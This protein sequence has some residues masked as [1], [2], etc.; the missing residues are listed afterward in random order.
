MESLTK[1]SRAYQQNSA[2]LVRWLDRLS[3]FDVSIKYKAGENLELTDSLNRNP[4]KEA[5][6]EENYEEDYVISFLSDFFKLNH[7]NGQRLNMDREIL[8]TSQTMNV[9]LATRRK[10]THEIA[11]PR[12]NISEVKP[13]IFARK[14]T[15]ASKSIS[16]QSN[17]IDST[18]NSGF[19]DLKTE[20]ISRMITII[21]ERT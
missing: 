8:T 9:G 17:L 18:N 3:H 5:A 7:K 11:S 14:R 16:G 13:K 6:T 19:T 2:G 12:N 15:H 20:K 10:M 1:R 4:I 21:E